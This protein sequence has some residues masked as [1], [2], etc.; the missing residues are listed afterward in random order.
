MLVNNVAQITIALRKLSKNNARRIRIKRKV[1]IHLLQLH[2]VNYY[3]VFNC[4][5]IYRIDA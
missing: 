3:I 2:D 1:L 4:N 5:R